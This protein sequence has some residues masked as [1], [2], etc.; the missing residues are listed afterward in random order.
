M[1]H[2]VLFHSHCIILLAHAIHVMPFFVAAFSY[3]L[4]MN[5]E[6]STLRRACEKDEETWERLGKVVVALLLT[7]AELAFRFSKRISHIN[8]GNEKDAKL[9]NK[10]ATSTGH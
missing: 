3:A 9:I 10:N 4:C 5:F 8:S 7:A 1:F 2:Y 6:V